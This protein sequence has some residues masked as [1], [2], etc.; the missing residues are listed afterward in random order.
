[1]RE[2][3]DLAVWDLAEIPIV[4]GKPGALQNAGISPLW[5]SPLGPTPPDPTCFAHE[6]GRGPRARRTSRR[7]HGL[8]L[9]LGAARDHRLPAP[10]AWANRSRTQV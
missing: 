9:A 7:Q 6:R 2:T 5:G 8:T 3:S 4:V 10:W 1:M